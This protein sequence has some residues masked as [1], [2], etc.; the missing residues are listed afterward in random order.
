MM[1]GRITK[2]ICIAF[3]A[4][5]FVSFCEKEGVGQSSRKDIEV[6]VK[7]IPKKEEAII[8]STQNVKSLANCLN[9]ESL[10]DSIFN[11]PIEVVVE[12]VG[13]GAQV[14]LLLP[15]SRSKGL[16]DPGEKRVSWRAS[17]DNE[18]LYEEGKGI[19]LGE[20]QKLTACLTEFRKSF[21]TSNGGGQLDKPITKSELRVKKGENY[22]VIIRSGRHPIRIKKNGK[23][24]SVTC[25]NQ[26]VHRGKDHFIIGDCGKKDGSF[27][28]RVDHLFC[29]FFGI[30]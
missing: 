17:E 15:F 23:L 22:Y 18:K 26:K 29:D 13:E 25:T 8:R 14:R 5:A 11:G 10:P 21:L 6:E 9:N 12:S 7:G 3:L 1:Q 2:R 30:D 27:D 4:C 16:F 24:Y 19:Y 20:V 28:E